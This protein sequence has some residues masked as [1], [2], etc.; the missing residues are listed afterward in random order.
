MAYYYRSK[1]QPSKS[2]KRYFANKM[3]EIEKFCEE[4]GI[5]SSFSNDSYYFTLNGQDYR[6]SNHT[7][8]MSNANAYRIVNGSYIQVREQ[9]HNDKREEDI[10]YIHASKTRIID[11]YIMI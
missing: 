3:K 6:V 1:W 8:E 11:I 9:Y 7:I 5:S 10:I 2:A 4:N